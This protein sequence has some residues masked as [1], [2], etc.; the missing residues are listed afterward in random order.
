MSSFVDRFRYQMFVGKPSV[1]FVNNRKVRV[2]MLSTKYSERYLQWCYLFGLSVYNPRG[3]DTSKGCALIWKSLPSIGLLLVTLL[4]GVLSFDRFVMKEI[5]LND[6]MHAV[7]IVFMII[8]G[9]VTFKRSSFLRGDT[10]FSWKYLLDLENLISDHLKTGIDF[11]KFFVIYTKKLIYT[12]C[13]FSFLVAFKIFHRINKKNVVRQVG[14][15]NL[16]FITL[17]VNFHALF[18]IELFN[19]MF[20]TIN[21][22]TLKRIAYNEADIFIVDV[23]NS[24]VGER[25]VELFQILKLIHFKLWKI[26]KIINGD[27]GTMLTLLI[28]QNTNTAIQTFYWIII[29]L[30]E[31]DLSENIRVISTYPGKYILLNLVSKLK[32]AKMHQMSTRLFQSLNPNQ[33]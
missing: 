5:T 28:I 25:I 6:L 29:E 24:D 19:F 1:W 32:Q 17:A 21:E 16:Q 26:V 20:E 27:F 12:L 2:R 10:K 33:F 7:F 9:I 18:Y 22:H 11:K 15:L 3:S 30:F 13:L 4:S 14:T 31:D 8:T 23:K